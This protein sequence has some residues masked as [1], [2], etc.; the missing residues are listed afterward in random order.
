VPALVVSPPA[1][2]MQPL[3]LDPFFEALSNE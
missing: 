3:N 1:G 2:L